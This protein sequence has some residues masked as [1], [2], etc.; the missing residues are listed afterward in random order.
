MLKRGG[1][2][3]SKILSDLNTQREE[4]KDAWLIDALY[5][6]GLITE[7]KITNWDIFWLKEEFGVEIKNNGNQAE[8][9]ADGK[10]IGVWIDDFE[11]YVLDGE[12]KLGNSCWN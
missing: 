5:N 11:L 2:L 4:K 10:L 3:F 1:D 12:I 7:K 6:N 8:L 9:W